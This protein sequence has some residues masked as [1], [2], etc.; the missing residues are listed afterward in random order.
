M[1][2][3]ILGCSKDM[4]HTTMAVLQWIG[5]PAFFMEAHWT[6]L[7][8]Y[9]NPAFFMDAVYAEWLWEE[10]YRDVHQLHNWA[11]RWFTQEFFSTI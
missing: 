9:R 5:N 10:A 11:V 3:S 6:S 2:R 1:E 7:H 4:L 8:L